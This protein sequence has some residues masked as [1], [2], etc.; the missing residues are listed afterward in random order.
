MYLIVLAISRFPFWYYDILFRIAC[1][2]L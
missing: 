1:F 2:L